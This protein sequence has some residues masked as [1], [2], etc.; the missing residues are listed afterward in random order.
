MDGNLVA[1][2]WGWGGVEQSSG[3]EP[4]TVISRSTLAG[5][6]HT[7]GPLVQSE[8][9]SVALGLLLGSDPPSLYTQKPAALALPVTPAS[10]FPVYRNGLGAGA[11]PGQGAQPGEGQGQAWSSGGWGGD[12]SGQR[13]GSRGK[14]GV[15]WGPCHSA[16]AG[17]PAGLGGS[18]SPLKPG[19]FIPLSS[20]PSEVS[21]AL[22]SCLCFLPGYMPL[23]KGPQLLPGESGGGL[24]SGR[25]LL[26]RG[27]LVGPEV[28]SISPTG[29]GVGLKPQKPGEPS[30]P[31]PAPPPASPF[32]PPPTQC[33]SHAF[34]LSRIWQRHWAGVPAR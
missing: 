9:R 11:F 8:N 34:F 29:L 23:G 6:S 21:R 4:L 5:A 26:P 32:R 10:V 14:G 2:M 16:C 31:C 20:A 15:E 12:P 19:E 17:L 1:K 30:P 22:P 18:V 28:P 13:A 33:P 25:A 24:G 7:A 3:T 27:G